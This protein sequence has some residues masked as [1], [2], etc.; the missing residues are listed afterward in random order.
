[1]SLDLTNI[2]HNQNFNASQ[3]DQS[4]NAKLLKMAHTWTLQNRYFDLSQKVD[5]FDANKLDSNVI[6]Q[7]QKSFTG[8]SEVTGLGLI[9]TKYEPLRVHTIKSGVMITSNISY[10]DNE[11]MDIQI[12]VLKDSAEFVE[13]PNGTTP[14]D[15]N[16]ATDF[17]PTIKLRLKRHYITI[18][19]FKDILERR[20]DSNDVVSKMKGL[21]EDKKLQLVDKIVV[22]NVLTVNNGVVNINVTTPNTQARLT[23]WMSEMI[24]Q[25]GNRDDKSGVPPIFIM[26]VVTYNRLKTEQSTTGELINS[27]LGAR[28]LFIPIDGPRK[29]AGLVGYFD[30]YEIWVNDKVMSNYQGDA[31]GTLVASGGVLTNKS[32]ILFGLPQSNAVRRGKDIFDNNYDFSA[33]SGDFER[34]MKNERIFAA[35]TYMVGTLTDPSL[36]TYA[37]V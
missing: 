34:F 17:L 8:V 33:D 25:L 24:S 28:G 19:G 12:D 4:Y 29:N 2:D 1:M 5:K 37:L 27:T 20:A 18:S 26:N 32:A 11:D 30:G 14:S 15:F 16:P 3:E 31:D 23:M 22:T 36:W 13:L 7:K 6:A 10:T 9:Q 21:L 35:E